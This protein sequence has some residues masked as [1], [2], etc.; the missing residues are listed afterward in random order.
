MRN[1][2]ACRGAVLQRGFTYL[3]L[4]FLLA[5][6]GAGLAALGQQW[7][8]AGQRER[9]AELR[10]RGAEF[11][12]ALALWRDAT[13]PGQANAPQGLQELLVDTRHQPPR[14]HLRR[15]YTD[16]FTGRAD[17]DLLTNPQ[18]R[19]VAVASRSR[20]PALRRVPVLP[21][22][23]GGSESAPAVGDWLFEA[24]PASPAVREKKKP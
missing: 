4:I 8:L 7:A 19:I 5:V 12:Q 16:P 3:L 14:H 1:G 17:W 15:L 9:E 21:L 13:P 22:R 20:Q 2:D 24:P 23:Q 18:G 6:A 10:F 11:G